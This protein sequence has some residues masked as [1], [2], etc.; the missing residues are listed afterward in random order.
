M[1]TIPF[2]PTNFPPPYGAP[3]QGLATPNDLHCSWAELIWSAISV[4]RAQ[5]AHLSMHGAFS[6]F[7]IIYRAAMLFANLRETPSGTITRSD[8][9]DGLDPSEKSAVSYFLG[10]TTAK[11]LAHRL[12]DVRW[13]MHLDVYRNNLAPVF[14]QSGVRP[15]LI[16]Q[17]SNGEWVVIEAK[18]RTGKFDS[19]AMTRAKNQ[20][21]NVATVSGVAPILRIAFLAHFA[22]GNLQCA[23]DDPNGKYDLPVDL[24]LSR[25]LLIGE[26]YRPFR[27]WL[28][29]AT[30]PETRQVGGQSYR[31]ARIPDVDLSIGLGIEVLD[32][33]EAPQRSVERVFVNG[34]TFVGG[35][36]L[37]VE[38]GE[39]W[40]QA[41]MLRQPQERHI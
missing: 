3:G 13:L 2:V 37:L 17:N 1:P 28:R 41:N 36:G 20:A 5:L 35:D 9:Y 25:Q 31:V 39:L 19:E 7:E 8:A 29:T 6:V 12:L 4:G 27:E 11:L 24:P 16:G 30:A 38:V 10:L 32:E 40:S 23:M 22:N 21:N 33:P 34:N 18:G 26:Y 14:G 15:D